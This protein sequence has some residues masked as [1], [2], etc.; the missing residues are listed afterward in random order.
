MTRPFRVGL[1]LAVGFL[2]LAAAC[3]SK[4]DEG[5][6][7]AALTGEELA[8]YHAAIDSLGETAG[9]ELLRLTYLPA[10]TDWLPST[11]YI[12]DLETAAFA[13]LPF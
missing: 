6:A 5:G 12:A 11:D 9:F 8:Q 7:L 3:G 10:G 4:A 13:V 1:L 2:C